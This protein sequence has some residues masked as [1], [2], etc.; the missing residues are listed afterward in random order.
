MK[1]DSEL[2]EYARKLLENVT[3]RSRWVSYEL[4]KT[5]NAWTKKLVHGISDVK[6]LVNPEGLFIDGKKI[7]LD[8]L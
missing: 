4:Y 7:D 6:Y 3:K 8:S 2:V 1:I 5:D